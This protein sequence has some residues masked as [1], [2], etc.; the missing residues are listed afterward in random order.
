[1]TKQLTKLCFLSENVLSFKTNKNYL[2]I[3]KGE[4]F[5]GYCLR[6]LKKKFTIDKSF[7]IYFIYDDKIIGEYPDR[8]SIF[9]FSEKGELLIDHARFTGL[10]SYH[11]YNDKLI[12]A[13]TN[14]FLGSKRFWTEL[15]LKTFESKE[16]KYENIYSKTVKARWLFEDELIIFD[17]RY[18]TER[19]WVGTINIYTGDIIWKHLLKDLNAEYLSTRWL[20]GDDTFIYN[21]KLYFYLSELI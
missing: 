14:Q 1:M 7:R 10:H 11:I 20:L 2:Y 3:N 6:T 13:T 9:I 8:T 4:S 17:N 5:C 19:D 15:N 18:R 21:K 12:T 16:I